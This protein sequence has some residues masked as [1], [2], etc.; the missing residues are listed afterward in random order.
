MFVHLSFIHLA[1][2]MATLFYV[3]S[4][5]ERRLGHFKLLGAYITCGFVG[6][7]AVFLFSNANTV[8]VGASGAIFGL[9]GI[10]FVS[11]MKSGDWKGFAVIGQGIVVNLYLTFTNDSI[12]V[13]GHLGGLVCGLLL[14]FILSLNQNNQRKTDKGRGNEEKTE[15]SH[16]TWFI[17]IAVAILIVAGLSAVLSDKQKGYN[18]PGMVQAPDIESVMKLSPDRT[19]ITKDSK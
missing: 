15:K 13:S 11:M 2:N 17:T 5:L 9:M 10:L 6:N 18:S 3:G 16:V 4:R 8:T 7:V 19:L 14:G 1:S 12:S